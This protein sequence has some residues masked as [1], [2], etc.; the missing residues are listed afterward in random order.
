[1]YDVLIKNGNIIDGSGRKP[2]IADLAIIGDKIV[3]IEKD[4]KKEAKR[5][6][7]VKGKNVAPGFIEIHSHDETQ[8]FNT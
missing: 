7:D 3:K 1:M 5:I 6:I 8:M 2:Y 4:I